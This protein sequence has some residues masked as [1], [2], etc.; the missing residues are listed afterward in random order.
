MDDDELTPE[1]KFAAEDPETMVP[2]AL[3]EGRDPEDIVRELCRLDWTPEAAW[4]LIARVTNDLERF[5]KSPQ[6]REEL[7]RE[8]RAQF[9]TGAATALLGVLVTVVS[10]LGALA[11]AMPFFVVSVGFFVVGLVMAGRGWVRWRLYSGPG[12]PFDRDSGGR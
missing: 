5:R 10:L 4:A 1:Q 6:S 11:G 3:S 9:W 8:A 7:V 12:L 2:R